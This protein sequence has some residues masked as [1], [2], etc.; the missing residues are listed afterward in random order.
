LAASLEPG[1]AVICLNYDTTMDNALAR[2]GWSPRRGYGFELDTKKVRT[3]DRFSH[4][5]QLRDVLLLK[6]HGSL[7]WLS[8]GSMREFEKVLEGRRAPNV[9]MTYAPKA[10]VRRGF[11][12]LF[13]PPL[14]VKFFAN[15]FWRRLWD[16]A[17]ERLRNAQVLVIVG[18]S[19]VQTDF[20][21]RSIVGSA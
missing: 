4:D 1:D 20:H 11:V 6:P 10:N 16:K 5:A 18:C 13:I 21:L 8:K 9:E 12:R 7:N 3:I 15:P 2:Q 17:F 14:Y 19:L